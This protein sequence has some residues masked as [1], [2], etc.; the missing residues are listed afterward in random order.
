MDPVEKI[1]SPFLHEITLKNILSFGSNAN[2]IKMG[3]LNV[4]IGPNGSGKSNIFDALS[5]IRASTKDFRSVIKGVNDWIW[6]GDSFGIAEIQVVVENPIGKQP[7]RH[8]ISFRDENQFFRLVDERIENREP[9]PGENSNFFYYQ[10]HNGFPVIKIKNEQRQLSRDS[11]EYNLS[12]LAQ[13]RDPENYPEITYLSDE[14]GK[15]RFYRDWPFGRNSIFRIPEKTDLP[16]DRLEEDFSN[17]RL[18]LNRI[19]KHLRVRKKIISALSDLYDGVS[20]FGIN[21]EGGTV[22][23]FFNEGDFTIPATRLSDGTLRYLCLIAILNDPEPP[24]LI[25]IEEPELGLHPDILPKLAEMLLDASKRTQI[26]VT[27]HSDILVDS[28]TDFPESIVVCE[29]QAGETETRR[30]NKEDLTEW[31]SKYRLGELWI[32]GNIGG[33]RW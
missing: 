11:I 15:I 17:L 6:K 10:Y 5:V 16:G 14:Y 28:L 25:C 13:R 22:Q 20:D 32:G 27:T 19:T 1:N 29:K 31:L 7:L 21:I 26:I 9:H 4:L 12:I 18:F 3:P 30:L 23:L 33:T 8:T 24:P 2:P